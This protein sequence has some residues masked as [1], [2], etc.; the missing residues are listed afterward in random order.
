MPMIREGGTGGI[1]AV[2]RGQ[3]MLEEHEVEIS[4]EK[5]LPLSSSMKV[6]AETQLDKSRLCDI[7]KGT[8]L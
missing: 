3:N 8:D 4:P 7:T 1:A 5:E 6:C 2:G